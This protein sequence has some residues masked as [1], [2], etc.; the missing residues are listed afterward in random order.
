MGVPFLPV[1]G[2]GG[3]DYLKVREDFKYIINPYD[4]G[5]KLVVVPSLTPDAALFH[6]FQADRS[7][8]V[9]ADASQNNKL[10]AQAARGAV[11][12]TV[13]EVV[14]KL[15]WS[16][17]KMFIPG[18]YITALVHAPG[19]AHPTSCP[20]YYKTDGNHLQEYKRAAS[21]PDT[22]HNYLQKYIT[23]LPGEAAYRKVIAWEK[24]KEEK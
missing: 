2:F 21:A 7:G 23:G 13:E 11:L 17:D 18:H 12:V 4:S 1:R 14:D 20:G 6:A 10:L 3:S 16:P 24:I 15:S 19:G 9:L 22:W 5:E 8:N